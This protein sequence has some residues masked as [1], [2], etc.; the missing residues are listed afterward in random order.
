MVVIID[1]FREEFG[2]LRKKMNAFLNLKIGDKI[3]KNNEEIIEIDPYTKYQFLT[4]W[5]Y[6]ESRAKT[7]KYLDHTFQEFFRFLDKIL[8]FIRTHMFSSV[9]EELSN[10]VC[11]FSTELIEGLHNFK[12]TYQ[13]N[14]EIVCKIDACILVIVDF[15]TETSSYRIQKYKSKIVKSN[16]FNQ[17]TPTALEL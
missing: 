1:N 4:R 7:I 2:E 10:E 14:V 9:I 15:K 5:W 6:G 16:S 3:F 11:E 17:I 8:A 13:D 12:Q